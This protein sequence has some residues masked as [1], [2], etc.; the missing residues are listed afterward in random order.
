MGGGSSKPIIGTST[1]FRGPEASYDALL[2]VQERDNMAF[3]RIFKRMI[4]NITPKELRELYSINQCKK[5]HFAL[6]NALAKIFYFTPVQGMAKGAQPIYWLRL[7]SAK[8]EEYDE[9]FFKNCFQVAYFYIRLLQIFCALS[10]ST[11]SNEAIPYSGGPYGGPMGQF[12]RMPGFSGGGPGF[13]DVTITIKIIFDK[14]VDSSNHFRGKYNFMSLDDNTLRIEK[15]GKTI[16]AKLE[17]TGRQIRITNV[18][19]EEEKIVTD[20][21]YITIK[22]DE[23]KDGDIVYKTLRGKRLDDE[24]FEIIKRIIKSYEE[25]KGIVKKK[26][27][28]GARGI[29]PPAERKELRVEYLVDRLSGTANK[30]YAIARALQLLDLAPHETYT[31]FDPYGRGGKTYAFTTHVFDFTYSAIIGNAPAILSEQQRKAFQ[32]SEKTLANVL[33]LSALEKLYFDDWMGIGSQKDAKGTDSYRIG[34]TVETKT[35]YTKFLN[36]IQCMYKDTS[37]AEISPNNITDLRS[38]SVANLYAKEKG[39]EAGPKTLKIETQE[40]KAKIAALKKLQSQLFGLQLAHN[41]RVKAFIQ[42]NIIADTPR[43]PMPNPKI[44]SEGLSRINKIGVDARRLLI[45]YY[46]KAEAIYNQGYMIIKGVAP[47][48]VYGECSVHLTPLV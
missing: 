28:D 29:A 8:K 18:Y 22:E 34:M 23:D 6:G 13:F 14:Y 48:N 26:D 31:T 39:A 33:G 19:Y 42:R 32:E 30:P 3:G 35:E 15:G 36:A 1:G 11:K 17:Y 2:R 25:K 46:V 24:L 40:N 43:G 12:F 38:F 20:P 27:T 37:I 9:Q 47:R 4:E 5:Y 10:I 44:F 21:K 45:D 7:D 41:A 16:T